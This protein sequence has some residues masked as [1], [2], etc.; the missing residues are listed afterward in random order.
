MH[1]N[2]S[3]GDI[4][5]FGG[6]AGDDQHF[7]RTHVYH[8]GAFHANSAVLTLMHSRFAFSLYKAQHFVAS[9]ERLVVTEADA[10]RRIVRE[11]NGRPAAEEYARLVGGPINSMRPGLPLR[12]W[13]WCWAAQT[14][15]AP[16]KAPTR[17]AA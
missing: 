15:C 13:W 3:L 6:S 1:C 8:G 14:M 2:M 5:L 9:D 16:Y 17:M 12:L 7:V 10:P 4:G 11:I